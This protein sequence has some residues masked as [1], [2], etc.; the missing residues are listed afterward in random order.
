MNYDPEADL[1]AVFAEHVRWGRLHTPTTSPAP[2]ENDRDPERKLRV[3]YVSPDLRFHALTRYFE[4]VLAHH[5]PSQVEVYCYA[6]VVHPDEVTLRLKE[7]AHGWRSTCGLS[8]VQVAEM[9]RADGIDILVDL[10]GHTAGTRL[11]IFGLKPA[12]V[13]ASW[14]GYLNTTGL[15]TVDYRITD[16]ILDPSG[17]STLGTE[18][19]V[20]LP[21]G[22]C[23][24]APPKNAPAL[25][26]LPALTRGYL[27]FGSLHN[28]FKLNAQVFD[29]WSRLLRALPKA[30]LLMF[31]DTLSGT[32]RSAYVQEFV[33]RGIE[34]ERL[35]FRRAA[36]VR[37]YMD[38][39]EEIDVCLDVFPWSGGVITCESL[40]MGVP[41]MSLREPERPD[42]MLPPC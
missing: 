31:R 4:P 36:D 23:C 28:L 34:A 41:V 1:D 11:R 24:F 10:A 12:P 32:A 37:T 5:D 13:Q 33:Q 39:Y 18:E 35:D 29:L 14:L 2:F 20:R 16:E 42:A 26:P 38:I 27:T 30:R 15:A 40:W 7:H 8:D 3:G 6:E 22:F 21:H 25:S 9:I 19:L 17:E